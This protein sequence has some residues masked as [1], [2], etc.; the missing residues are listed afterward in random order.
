M[1][2]M[3]LPLGLSYPMRLYNGVRKPARITILGQE[4]AGEVAAAGAGVTAFQPGD[5]V[6]G[7]TGFTLGAYAEYICLPVDGGEAAL[8]L[9]PAN[10]ALEEA[11]ALPLGG[12][13]ALHFLGRAELRR[14]QHALIIGAGGS[15]GTA[16]VQLAKHFG[17]EVTAV[18][19][20]TKLE[21]L[22]GIGADHVL[23]YTR[24]DFTRLGETFDVIFDG[25]GKGSLTAT[26]RALKPEGVYLA[27]NPGAA[28][29]ARGRWRALT[30]GKRVVSG[31]ASRTPADLAHLR[32][33][34]ETGAL[35][36]VIDRRYPLEQ[37]VA[38]H[39]YVET[40]EKQ[41]NVVITVA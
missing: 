38:A 6:F 25:V 7:D 12:L 27:V 1:R 24:E 30:G 29:L 35:R 16:A 20:G 10:L 11:A 32:D 31:S 34:V 8:A 9:K 41:G 15:I 13:E 14:G 26:L 23:D 22:R 39:R 40:G 17:A 4:V 3:E 33:L 19:R 2:R 5:A 28:A 36:P 18:D 21:M 37:M